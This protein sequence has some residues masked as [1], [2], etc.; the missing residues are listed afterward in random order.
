[1]NRVC[2]V[3]VG[4]ASS[5]L[6]LELSVGLPAREPQSPQ[7]PVE[8]GSRL[9]L[10]VDHYLI[11]RL[12]GARLVLH[13]PVPQEVVLRFDKPWEGLFCGY[14]TV[15]K[16]ADRFRLYY[17]GLPQAGGD[18]SAAEVTCYAESSDGVHWTKPKLG[19]YEVQGTRENNVILAQMPPLSHN[20][21]PMID[22]RP[23]VPPEERYKALAGTSGLVPLVSA[24]GIHWKKL[25]DQP[26][27]TQGAFDSQNVCFWSEAE[28]CY[29]CYFRSWVDGVRR[30]SR[31]TSRDFLV[32]TPPELMQYRR[33]EG[34]VPVEHI[35]TN[36]T[37]PYFRASHVYIATAARFM[38]GRQA[39]TAEQAAL[40]GVHP[41][42]LRDVSDGVLLTSRGGTFY[43]RTFLESFIRPG[44]GP[45]NWVSRTNY[46]ALG[47]VQT[48]LHE[49]SLYVQHNYGQ[50]TA[51]LRRY[52]LRLDGFT[53]VHAPYDG[54]E[55]QTKPLVFIGRRLVLNYATSAAGA[56]RVEIQD[57]QGKPIP[58]YGLD[59]AVEL[60]GNE[61]A[62]VVAWKSGE[63]LSRLAGQPIRLRFVLKDADLF[64]LKFE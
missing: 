40:I 31:T 59:E 10:F 18:G 27:I 60:L 34:P 56:V 23:S 21:S 11:D 61:I 38:P 45:E 58:G 17:R 24:D 25:R 47:I 7:V 48:G 32:W 29:V 6:M 2:V 57:A 49:M 46:P 8:I 44:I 33:P 36:Q 63:D 54:G 30:I 15:L 42:Y 55:M 19:L 4:A 51:H 12:D 1:M 50:P 43:D 22:T 62:R 64:S 13:R 41:D 26:V 20:F 37:Q 35:Y 39:I 14:C 53:S 28:Q 52:T 9:E 16:D 3:A 5:W